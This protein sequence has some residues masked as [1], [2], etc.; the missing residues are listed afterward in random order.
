VKSSVL[1]VEEK[2]QQYMMVQVW[3]FYALF[4]TNRAIILGLIFLVP[5]LISLA[6][7]YDLGTLVFSLGMSALLAVNLSLILSRINKA[8]LDKRQ[9]IITVI[10]A[11]AYL[12]KR[13]PASYQFGEADSVVET[14]YGFFIALRNGKHIR[15]V[16]DDSGKKA[17]EKYRQVA[18]FLGVHFVKKEGTL[19]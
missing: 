7:K 11:M 12:M 4:F 14:Y 1:T 2:E 19:E 16:D 18:D 9:G 8:M 13:K 3:P 10:S 15:F 5:A 6:I 17:K